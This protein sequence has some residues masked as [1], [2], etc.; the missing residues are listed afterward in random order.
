MTVASLLGRIQLRKALLKR[1]CRLITTLQKK[2][3]E[4]FD[5]SE[6]VREAF[7]D[8][9]PVVALES[10]IIT[11]GMP[12]PENYETATAVENIVRAEVMH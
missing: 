11:H 8:N 6:E 12:F 2:P 9:K 4:L 5:I 3:N 10:T 7:H 1:H